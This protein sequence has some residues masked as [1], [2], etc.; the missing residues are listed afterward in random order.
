MIRLFIS[1]FDDPFD[2]TSI[3]LFS[4]R[5]KIV[6]HFRAIGRIELAFQVGNL[7]FQIGD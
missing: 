5:F 4:L 7:A 2:L 1:E 6:F 3:Q